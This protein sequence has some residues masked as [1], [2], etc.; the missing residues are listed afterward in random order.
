MKISGKILAA[1]TAA[2]LLVGAG[3]WYLWD[4]RRITQLNLSLADFEFDSG[5]W[6]APGNGQATSRRRDNGPGRRTAAWR[7]GDPTRQED[8][9]SALRLYTGLGLG[10]VQLSMD[11]GDTAVRWAKDKSTLRSRVFTGLTYDLSENLMLGMEY[12]ALAVGEPLFALDL[13]GQHFE[14]DNPF[15]DHVVDLKLSY[16]L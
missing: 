12:R 14:L 11:V 1:L 6:A 15:Q 4:Q 7:H 5:A 8:P 3:S 13:G 10:A 2:A 9:L 16:G